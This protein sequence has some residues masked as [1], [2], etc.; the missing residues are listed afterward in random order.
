MIERKR[1][2]FLTRRVL[3]EIR[4]DSPE[5]WPSIADAGC[6][7]EPDDKG[8]FLVW[9]SVERGVPG[10]STISHECW[11]LFMT[12]LGYAD[13]NEYSFD[14][15]DSEIYAYNFQILFMDVLNSLLNSKAYQGHLE[16]D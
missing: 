9:F 6:Y 10:L 4:D 14:V 11:H 8:E 1:F 13:K 16:N 3:V 2:S 15:L 5:G 12:I 7:T